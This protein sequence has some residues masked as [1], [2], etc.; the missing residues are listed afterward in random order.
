MPVPDLNSGDLYQKNGFV[1][2]VPGTPD[3]VLGSFHRR[4]TVLPC[5]LVTRKKG[6]FTINLPEDTTPDE[7]C[8]WL[9]VI[10]GVTWIQDFEYGWDVAD[11]GD[12]RYLI[13]TGEFD[14]FRHVVSAAEIADDFEWIVKISLSEISGVTYNDA[15]I[16]MQADD[17]S[18]F[19][20]YYRQ[21]GDLDYI[22]FAGPERWDWITDTDISDLFSPY[23]QSL[24]LRMARVSGTLT[25]SFSFDNET[26]TEAGSVSCDYDSMGCFANV[27]W[28]NS[29]RY[30]MISLN[31][32]EE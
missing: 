25:G 13:D 23:D 3:E 9:E 29:V 22:I 8:K 17:E 28:Q 4:Q 16:F 11:N 14:S 10:L 18:R 32:C 31:P 2:I 12:L 27:Y 21:D 19:Y 15:G 7:I 6:E 1:K 5:L 26:W 20:L 30:Q 24:Y